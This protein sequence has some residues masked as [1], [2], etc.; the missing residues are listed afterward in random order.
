MSA[1]GQ[2][3]PLFFSFVLLG[4]L[5]L[6]GCATPGATSQ[7]VLSQYNINGS[8]KALVQC[9]NGVIGAAWSQ[10]TVE[11]A[12]STAL[13]LAYAQGGRACRI[14]GI[15]G[16]LART[17]YASQREEEASK[18]GRSK[19]S[20]RSLPSE[21]APPVL[22]T[23]ATG[24]F[25]NRDGDVVTNEHVV[26]E[27]SLVKVH[28][29]GTTIPAEVKKVDRQ[30]DLALISTDGQRSTNFAR[31]GIEK[32]IRLGEPVVTLGYPLS[33]VLSTYPKV[34]DGAVSSL[35]GIQDDTRFL[36][37][38]APIQPGNSGGPLFNR[39][40]AVI[41]VVTASLN[42]EWAIKATGT[43]P[44]NVNFAIKP[45]PLES[46]LNTTGTRYASSGN[47]TRV[48]ETPDIIESAQ[49]YVVQVTC[50]K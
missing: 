35:A 21:P 33:G 41:G 12:K 1:G 17:Y 20:K 24:F 44:Q 23:S 8:P 36:Q 2:I 45:G 19:P 30:N 50:W 31:L 14:T 6:K 29:E 5:L 15:N 7:Q 34:T 18:P 28:H 13:R 27:C 22:E 4:I 47:L 39:Y 46:F 32:N 43:A 42:T 16:R 38:S 49:S 26:D 11:S 9:S 10:P 3:K 40:G 48:L 37:I 25:V